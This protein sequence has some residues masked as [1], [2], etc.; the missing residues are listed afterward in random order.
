[1]AVSTSLCD[2]LESLTFSDT[3]LISITNC[4]QYSTID[5]I[6]LVYIDKSQVLTIGVMGGPTDEEIHKMNITRYERIARD[7]A[8]LVVRSAEPGHPNRWMRVDFTMG[9]VIKFTKGDKAERHLERM[10]RQMLR[11]ELHPDNLP[12]YFPCTLRSEELMWYYW[13]LDRSKLNNWE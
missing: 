11:Q 1:M 6:G 9:E 7:S 4:Q 10:Y 12:N 2:Q 8:L 3:H 5:T 13:D